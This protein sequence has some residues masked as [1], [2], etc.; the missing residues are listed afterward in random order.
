MLGA[1]GEEALYLVEMEEKMTIAT[2]T[3]MYSLHKAGLVFIGI[4]QLDG[5]GRRYLC[6]LF[7]IQ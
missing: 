1:P 6:T 4:L 2:V 3:G 5:N 7:I